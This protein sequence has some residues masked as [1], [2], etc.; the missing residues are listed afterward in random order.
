MDEL[1][2]R[3]AR[4]GSKKRRFGFQSLEFIDPEEI[5]ES[6]ASEIVTITHV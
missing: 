5:G 2:N 6:K 3:L 1:G 4:V